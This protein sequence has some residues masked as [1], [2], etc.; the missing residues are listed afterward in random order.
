MAIRYNILELANDKSEIE[1]CKELGIYYKDSGIKTFY[2]K[3]NIRGVKLYSST[4][5]V[6]L[7][8]FVGTVFLP[9]AFDSR[10]II[11]V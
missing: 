3:G 1:N 8:G 11:K 10:G 2:T 5:S 7:E 6:A 4:D 9:K